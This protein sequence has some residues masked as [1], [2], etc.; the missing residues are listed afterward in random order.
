MTIVTPGNNGYLI[1]ENGE[2]LKPP[3]GWIFLPAGDAGI[4]R[5]VTAKGDCWR[6]QIRKGRRLISKGIWAPEKNI[7]QA[8]AEVLT[9]RQT[10]EYKKK[11]VYNAKRREEQQDKYQIEFTEAIQR[12]LNFHKRYLK[13]QK[14]M[15][16]AISLH[17]TPIGSG[18]VARTKM[19]PLRERAS[20][21]VIAWMRHQTTAYDNLKIAR[22]K[23][24]RRTVRRQLAEQSVSL[25]SKYREGRDITSDCPLYKATKQIR[26]SND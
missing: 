14:T 2:Y 17:A 19:I 23:G 26:I 9:T 18:T 8:K 16:I 6:V 1:G 11:Q 20:H 10:D 13:I 4:T 15:A 22:I 5:K 3:K 12:Y 24:E 25:L 7:E 21:A